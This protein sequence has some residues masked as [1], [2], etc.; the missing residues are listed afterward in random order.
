L[1]RRVGEEQDSPSPAHPLIQLDKSFRG[2]R[3]RLDYQEQL[4]PAKRISVGKTDW[5]DA[6]TRLKRLEHGG[7]LCIEIEALR[8]DDRQAREQQKLRAL[9]GRAWTVLD[10][11]AAG[12][13]GQDQNR[14]E[15]EQDGECGEDCPP[16]IRRGC[17]FLAKS[18]ELHS[19]SDAVPIVRFPRFG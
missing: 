4:V 7:R 10:A 15:Q 5:N 12:L 9:A 3:S 2:L 8:K 19:L 16:A 14:D 17:A 11:M 6:V 13:S 1:K 18:D